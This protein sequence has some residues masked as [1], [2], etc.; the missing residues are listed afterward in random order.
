MT[1]NF[2]PKCRLGEFAIGEMTERHFKKAD[3]EI[4][5]SDIARILAQV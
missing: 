5:S 3:S 1:T 4:F 2:H